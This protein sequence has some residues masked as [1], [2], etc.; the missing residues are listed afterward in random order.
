M[1]RTTVAAGVCAVLLAASFAARADVVAPR[2]TIVVVAPEPESVEHR[3]SLIVFRGEQTETVFVEHAGDQHTIVGR[4][5]GIAAVVD[6]NLWVYEA[7]RMPALLA[8]CEAVDAHPEGLSL[9]RRLVGARI[10]LI[11]RPQLRRVHGA[12]AFGPSA[13]PGDLTEQLEFG[14]RHGELQIYG[15]VGSVVFA[16][17]CVEQYMCGAAH[18]AIDCTFAAYDLAMPARRPLA[19][20]IGPGEVEDAID[21]VFA[22]PSEEMTACASDVS[23]RSSFS[24][25][26]VTPI[27]T[28]GDA[29]LYALVTVDSAYA[30]STGCWSSYRTCA[31]TRAGEM[32]IDRIEPGIPLRGDDLAIAET[33]WGGESTDRADAINAQVRAW[34]AAVR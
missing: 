22:A 31:W 20:F 13:L 1:I 34:L 4:R 33:R 2:P 5:E 23:D 21:A 16:R 9:L 14:F 15:M 29:L 28:E 10:G 12:G 27:Y 3:W 7:S 30:C 11:E 17:E 24:V 8:D 19:D 32:P 26:A 18:G 25:D 6:G